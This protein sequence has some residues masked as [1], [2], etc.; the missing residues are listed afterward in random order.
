MSARLPLFPLPTVLYPGSVLPLHIFEP[1]YRQL[2]A[3]CLEDDAPFGVIRPGREREAPPP[4]TVGCAGRIRARDLLPDE[5]SNIIVVGQ[6]RFR[7]RRYLE[8][9]T[10][11]LMALVA[12][13]EDHTIDA[14]PL[15]TEELE[16]LFLAYTE[17]MHTLHDVVREAVTLTQDPAAL[18]FQVAG[19]IDLGTSSHLR[20]L[21]MQSAKD[22]IEFLTQWLR[23]QVTDLADRARLHERA[24]GNGHS[25]RP[26]PPPQASP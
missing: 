20:L 13:F 15:S 3:D 17:A 11:Y 25:G 24:R 18:T 14:Q 4:G 8:D 23:P 10:P 21:E 2:V 16:R 22:R 1:R 7:V 12:E 5:R 19:S 26:Y 6:E 9:D